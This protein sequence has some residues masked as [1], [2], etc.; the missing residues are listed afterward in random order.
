MHWSWINKML[1]TQIPTYKNVL[2]LILNL[3]NHIIYTRYNYR[4]IVINFTKLLLLHVINIISDLLF[5]YL[6]N[7]ILF[8]ISS[9]S[10]MIFLTSMTFSSISSNYRFLKFHFYA[11]LIFKFLNFF[12]FKLYLSINRDCSDS[13]F[14]QSPR[15]IRFWSR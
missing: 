3:L 9:P 13:F 6:S 5:I 11:F 2:I 15:C 14:S 4:S 10:I 1:F 8:N 7:F 12:S